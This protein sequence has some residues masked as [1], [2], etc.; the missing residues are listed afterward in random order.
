[1]IH[2]IL[3]VP[4]EAASLFQKIQIAPVVNNN[5]SEVQVQAV[6]NE[7]TADAP[8]PANKKGIQSISCSVKQNGTLFMAELSDSLPFDYMYYH[9]NLILNFY[10]GTV[11]TGKIR[12][13]NKMGIIRSVSSVQFKESAQLSIVLTSWIEDPV[14]DYVQD[15]KTVMVSLRPAK[16]PPVSSSLPGVK[17]PEKKGTII[18]IDPGHGGKD[19][20]AIGYNGIKEKDVVFSIALQLKDMLK[21]KPGITILLTREKDIFIPLRERTEFANN[22]KADLFVSIHA[23]AV[24]GD[25]KRKNGTRGYKIYFLS[26]AKNEDDKLV[27][28]RENAVIEL[29]EQPQNYSNLQNVLIDLAGNE[30]LRES[31]DLCILV[32]LKF[33]SLL[34]KKVEKLHLGVGQANFWVLNGAYM[35]SILVETGFLSNPHEAQLLVDKEFQKTMANALCEAIG[36]F[37]KQYGVGNE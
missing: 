16:R 9:P 26:Q 7:I 37:T 27:A 22:K 20:G 19:P 21:T 17:A 23:D 15:T 13:L 32:D 14:F 18:V 8:L 34:K 28:M 6:K 36:N 11:D 24:P 29:E 35:P 25:N 31:Q 1:L 10:G 3:F 4:E 30:F 12:L 5:K 33:S 2:G